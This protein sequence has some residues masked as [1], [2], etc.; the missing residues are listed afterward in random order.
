MPN[1]AV[2]STEAAP[3]L[4]AARTSTT[5][6]NTLESFDG[7]R[8]CLLFFNVT[9]GTFT[10]GLRLRVETRDP[11]SRNWVQIHD[12]LPYVTATGMYEYLMYPDTVGVALDTAG[13][14]GLTAINNAP[15]PRFWRIV[16]AH[17]DAGSFTYSV[18]AVLLG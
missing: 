2:P 16:V 10:T 4:A 6:S 17:G 5:T 7:H 1:V 3:L 15:L 8:G 12:H 9:A 14:G 18:G 13:A 11:V